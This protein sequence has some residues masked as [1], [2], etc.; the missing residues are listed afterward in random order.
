MEDFAAI[1]VVRAM[2]YDEQRDDKEMRVSEWQR[3]P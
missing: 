1:Q 2:L 3:Q